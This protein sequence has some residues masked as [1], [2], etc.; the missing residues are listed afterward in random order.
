MLF[1]RSLWDPVIVPAWTT[2]WSNPSPEPPRCCEKQDFF[3]FVLNLPHSSFKSGGGHI[4]LVFREGR[5]KCTR[6]CRSGRGNSGHPRLP[7]LCLT[8]AHKLYS[9]HNSEDRLGGRLSLPPHPGPSVCLERPGVSRCHAPEVKP[10]HSTDSSL[11]QA[12]SAA[13]GACKLQDP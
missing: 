9:Q 12:N 4:I 6:R 13:R 5:R 10:G 7:G 2:L 8:S 11:P 1:P 3:S